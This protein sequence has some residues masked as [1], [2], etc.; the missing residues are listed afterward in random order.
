MSRMIQIDQMT[1]KEKLLAMEAVMG[2]SRMANCV[3]FTIRNSR[4]TILFLLRLQCQR[5]RS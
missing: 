1:L 4:F 5:T 3:Y 2:E